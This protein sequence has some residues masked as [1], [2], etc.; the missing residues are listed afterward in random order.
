MELVA[1]G[2]P[3]ILDRYIGYWKPYTSGHDELD[4]D[5]ALQ[6]EVPLAARTLADGRR[7]TDRL[8]AA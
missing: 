7:N 4:K 5:D 1:A 2:G 8:V 3:A 6:K